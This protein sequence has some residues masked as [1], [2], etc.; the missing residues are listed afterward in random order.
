MSWALRAT[1][2]RW[3]QKVLAY[4]RQKVPTVTSRARPST[5]PWRSAS[6]PSATASGGSM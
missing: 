3:I 5:K 6:I 4:I 1:P 2:K